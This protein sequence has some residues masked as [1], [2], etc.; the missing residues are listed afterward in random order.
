MTPPSTSSVYLL[1]IIKNRS[2]RAFAP[3]DVTKTNFLRRENADSIVL[4][5]V[6]VIASPYFFISLVSGMG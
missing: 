6:L 4:P 3:L 2:C 1:T 5:T